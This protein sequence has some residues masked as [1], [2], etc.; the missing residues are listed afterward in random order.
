M[1][2]IANVVIH[3]NHSIIEVRDNSKG[4]YKFQAGNNG[5]GD[6]EEGKH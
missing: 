4:S 6:G 2:L 5:H 1:I 3:V